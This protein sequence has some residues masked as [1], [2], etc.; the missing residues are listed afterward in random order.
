[1]KVFVCQWKI[2]VYAL[3]NII[4]V[5]IY[6]WHNMW[7]ISDMF[8]LFQQNE[9]HSSKENPPGRLADAVCSP[10]RGDTIRWLEG[11]KWKQAWIIE[12]AFAMLIGH[13]EAEKTIVSS[14]WLRARQ[15]YS[16]TDSPPC[17]SSLSKTLS[18]HELWSRLAQGWA[19]V[20]AG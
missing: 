16:L 18:Q 2:G 15:L 12:A 11:A 6:L 19:E 7:F 17:A 13:G 4:F 20:W 8:S 14:P 1:M 9:L 3:M 10:G 5:F